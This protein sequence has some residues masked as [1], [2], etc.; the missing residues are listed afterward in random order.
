MAIPESQLDTWSH[1]GAVA[2]SRDTY[3]EIK[4][5][6]E[7][8]TVPYAQKDYKVFLQGSY[9]N[10]TNVYKESDVDIVIQLNQTFKSDTSKLPLD[11]VAAWDKVYSNSSY[12][13]YDFRKD[14]LTVLTDKYGNAVQVGDK[15]ISIAANG[16]RR[17]ADVITSLQYRRY[18]KFKGIFDESYDVGICFY[19]KSRELIANYPTQ[20]SANMTTKHQLTASWLKPMVRIVKNMRNRLID[21][22]IIKNGIAPSYYIEGLL[23]NVPNDKFGTSYADTFANVMNWI[24]QADRSKFVCANQQYYLLRD[25]FHTSWSTSNCEQFL[26]ALK[27]FWNNW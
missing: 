13:Y 5:V 6:L 12:G 2:G 8:S 14:V 21:D 10:D 17:K 7:A 15:A 23:Y 4:K 9:G 19:N 20:H 18:Y 24:L 25:N 3:S 26:N 1:Q 16:N 11:Q 22:K 27:S